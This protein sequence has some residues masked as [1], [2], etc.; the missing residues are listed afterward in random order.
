[1]TEQTLMKYI[2]KIIEENKNNHSKHLVSIVI[3]AIDEW[4]E[5]QVQDIK[6]IHWNKSEIVNSRKKC[7]KHNQFVNFKIDSEIE[8]KLR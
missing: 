3:L 2:D 6:P 4:F 1:M 7:R 5:G 8:S